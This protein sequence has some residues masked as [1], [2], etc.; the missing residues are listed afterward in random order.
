MVQGGVLFA[1]ASDSTEVGKFT[2]RK[3]AKTALET[4]TED[5]P[6]GLEDPIR[7][8]IP[9]LRLVGHPYA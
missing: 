4:L 1:T 9:R 7:R 6:M 2:I 5:L 3:A 8:P